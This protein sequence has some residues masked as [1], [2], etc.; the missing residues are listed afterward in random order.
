MKVINCGLLVVGLLLPPLGDYEG[1]D[2]Q[3]PLGGIPIN[4][5]NGS[6]GVTKASGMRAGFADL[7][8]RWLLST[9]EL[10]NINV[11]LRLLKQHVIPWVQ[12]M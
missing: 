5:V 8:C 7:G 6:V 2:E 1:Q 11:Y 9:G 3:N 10:F 12:R 4:G